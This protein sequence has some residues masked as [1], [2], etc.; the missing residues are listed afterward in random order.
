MTDKKCNMCGRSYRLAER[1]LHQ[2]EIN[3]EYGSPFDMQL[4]QLKL[5]ED[6]I[7]AMVKQFK[8]SP[9]ITERLEV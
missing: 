7:Q 4:W 6:C 5:C 9:T 3:F 2:F 1:N 8:I